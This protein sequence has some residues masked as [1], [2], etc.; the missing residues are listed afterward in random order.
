MQYF[1]RIPSVCPN[2]SAQMGKTSLQNWCLLQFSWKCDGF[3]SKYCSA[4]IVT[5][6][7]WISNYSI[8]HSSVM[9]R[10]QRMSSPLVCRNLFW[11]QE[12]SIST[13]I[14]TTTS[15]SDFFIINKSRNKLTSTYNQL[16]IL[17]KTHMRSPPEEPHLA[18]RVVTIS[19]F[20]WL[21]TSL[22][23]LFLVQMG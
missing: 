1:S 16:R 21:Q 3:E 4:L 23:S 2:R 6:R 5:S 18:S 19:L 11:K 13:N 10:K 14:T 20:W 7:A 22:L 15:V 8:H 12:N 17:L 9:P